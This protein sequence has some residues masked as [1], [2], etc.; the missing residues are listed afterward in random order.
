MNFLTKLDEQNA[1]CLYKMTF[2]KKVEKSLKKVLTIE[3]NCSIIVKLT[4]REEGS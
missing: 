2:L 4:S 3:K 1:V